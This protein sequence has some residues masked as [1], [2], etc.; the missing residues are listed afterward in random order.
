MYK[1]LILDF[2]EKLILIISKSL[3]YYDLDMNI[4]YLFLWLPYG[5]GFTVYL[6]FRQF[7]YDTGI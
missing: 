1:L 6:S 4:L 5:A 7:W 2:S 3:M